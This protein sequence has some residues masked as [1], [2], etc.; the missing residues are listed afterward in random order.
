MKNKTMTE[1]GNNI[2]KQ[3]EAIRESVEMPR[4]PDGA[5]KLEWHDYCDEAGGKKKGIYAT[6]QVARS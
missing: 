5:P 4:L 3:L 6:L 1:A 2:T